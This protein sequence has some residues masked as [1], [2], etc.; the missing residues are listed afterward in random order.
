MYKRQEQGSS[1]GHLQESING[2]ISFPFTIKNQ[3]MTSLSTLDASIGLKT[4]LLDYQ[5]DFFVNSIKIANKNKNNYTIVGDKKD[6]SKLFHFYEILKKHKIEIK[7]LK[8]NRIVNGVEYEQENSFLIPKNQKNS[9]LINAMLENRT[10]FKDSLFYDVSALSFLHS[11][12]LEYSDLII[13]EETTSFNFKKPEGKIIS[14]S[15]YAY[16]FSWDLSLIHI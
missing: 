15:N 11:F 9:R 2:E 12:D 16:L 13:K 10:K 5:Y 3:L 6:K 4:E 8:K 14:K 7:K 1:R